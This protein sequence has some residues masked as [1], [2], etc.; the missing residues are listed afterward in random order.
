MDVFLIEDDELLERYNDIWNN[1][2]NSIKNELDCEPI[3]NRKFL[4]NKIRS[5]G[6]EA[7]D[8]H[9]NEMPILV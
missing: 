9:D 3:Y 6:N 1:V 7:K 8:F 4:K 2:R 5:Y